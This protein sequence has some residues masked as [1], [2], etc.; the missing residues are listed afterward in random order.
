M[1]SCDFVKGD[2]GTVSI[3]NATWVP[4]VNHKDESGFAVYAVKDYTNELAAAHPFLRDLDDPLGWLRST[5]RDV[6]G[7]DFVIDDGSE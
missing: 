6:I 3:E 7:D 5:S 4:L 1:L 2:D